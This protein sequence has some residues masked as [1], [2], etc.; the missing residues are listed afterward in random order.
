MIKVKCSCGRTL[1]VAE[2]DVGS[3]LSCPHCSQPFTVAPDPLGSPPRLDVLE[4]L[5]VP[6]RPAVPALAAVEASSAAL[7]MP[8]IE[9]R[10]D[11]LEAENRALRKMLKHHLIG[12]T[13]VAGCLALAIGLVPFMR[14]KPTAPKVPPPQP[15]QLPKIIEADGFV[16]KDALGKTRIAIGKTP[17]ALSSDGETYGVD[18]FA[19]SGTRRMALSVVDLPQDQEGRARLT[20]FDSAAKPRVMVGLGASLAGFSLFSAD[21]RVRGGLTTVPEG[22]VALQLQDKHGE[23]KLRFGVRGESD[24][25]FVEVVKQPIPIGTRL[26]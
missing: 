4:I 25:G 10:L 2:S 19:P 13:A 26:P 11:D 22:T 20:L 18:V 6:G 17:V 5:K 16:V 23:D 12:S 3:R 9:R 14:G 24:D 21:S 7:P 15:Y 8:D 1:S